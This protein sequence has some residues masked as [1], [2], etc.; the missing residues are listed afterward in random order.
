M[1]EISDSG[2]VGQYFSGIVIAAAI[3][4]LRVAFSAGVPQQVI[5]F[6][7]SVRADPLPDGPKRFHK[8]KRRV[9]IACVDDTAGR[10]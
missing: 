4:A 8:A 7:Q 10:V 9:V 2:R 1:K 5:Q 3:N 6:F